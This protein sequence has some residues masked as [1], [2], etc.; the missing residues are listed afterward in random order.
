MQR[1]KILKPGKNIEKAL[2]LKDIEIKNIKIIPSKIRELLIYINVINAKNIEDLKLLHQRIKNYLDEYEA[3]YTLKYN[4]NFLNIDNLFDIAKYIIEQMILEK[5]GLISALVKYELVVFGDEISI[6]LPSDI[7]INECKQ[8][9]LNLEI[10]KRLQYIYPNKN[11]KVYF[12]SNEELKNYTPQD[13]KIDRVIITDTTVNKLIEATGEVFNV[14]IKEIKTKTGLDKKIYTFYITDFKKSLACKKF[15]DANSNVEIGIGDIVKVNGIYKPNDIFNQEYYVDIKSIEK[16]GVANHNIVDDAPKKRVELN[17]KTS[18]SEMYSNINP[19]SIAKTLEKIG[20]SSF[21]VCDI[22]VVHAYPFI[23]NNSSENMKVIFGVDAFLVDDDKKLV[24]N[25][26][27]NINILDETY[28][29]FDIETTGL[30]PYDDKIIEIGAVKICNNEVIDTYSKFINPEIPISEF[31]TNLTSITND[32]VKDADKIDV[33]LPDFFEFIKNSTLV[34]HNAKFDIGFLVQQAKKLGI[35]KTFRY[36]DTMDMARLVIPDQTKF[37]LDALCK[38]LNLINEHHHRAIDD[39]RVTGK[40]FNRLMNLILKLGAIKLEDINRLKINE[41]VSGVNKITILVKDKEGLKILYELISNSFLKYYGNSKPRILKSDL[42][43]YRSHFLIS[44]SPSYGFNEAG[45]LVELYFRGINEKYIE[46]RAEFYDYIQLLPIDCYEKEIAEGEVSSKESIIAM[47]KYLFNLGKKLNKLVVAVGNTMYMHDYE[48]KGKSVL[49]MVSGDFRGYKYNTNA[50]FRTTNVMLE[51]FKYLGD[52][53]AYDI[54]V[55][56]T[57]KIS[58]MIDRIQPIPN[59]FYP[60]KLEN[61]KETVKKLTMDKAYELYGENIPDFIQKR[62]DKELNSI[63]NNGFSVLYLIA[64]K[65]V[66]KSVDNGYLVGSRGSVGSSIVAYLMGITEVN[67]LP[68]HYRCPNKECKNVELFENL[69]TSGVDLPEKICPKCN[70]KYIRDGHA[71]PFEVFMGFHGEKVPDIDL[72]FSSEYQSEIHK[73][74]E[75]IFGKEFVF[76]A[77]TISTTA[78]NNAIGYSKKYF[79]EI[80]KNYI[81]KECVK[82]FGEYIQK[83]PKQEIF[84][85][86]LLKSLESKNFAEICRIAKMIEGTRK[87]TGQHPGGMVVVP[88]DMS[89]YDFTP[90]QKPANDVDSESTT[91]HFDYHVMDE[92]LVKLDIL[93]HDD[94]TTLKILEDLTGVSPFTL[95]LNDSKVL[96]L[97][98]STKALGVTSEQ[99]GTDLGTNGI[100]EFGTNFVKEMLKFTKPTTFT[101]LV[102]ISGLSHGTDVWLNNAKDYIVSNVAKLNEVITVRDDIMNYL[103]SQGMDKGL[104]FKIMEFVRKGKP[105]KQ[106]EQW[107]QYEEE[108]KKAGIKEWYIESCGKIKYMFPKGHAVAY[109]MMAIRIAYFK[110]YYPLEFYTAYLNRKISSFTLSKMFMPVEKLKARLNELDMKANKNPNDKA[111]INVLE[112]LIEMSYRGIELA[113]VNIL[114]SSANYFKIDNGKILIP[115][116]GVDQLGEVVAKNIV[117]ARSERPFSSQEDL[118]KRA[119][120]N[121]SV[122]ET[123]RKYNV[124][125]N[126]SLTDQQTLF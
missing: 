33:V 89:V 46:K 81:I 40:I 44:S 125:N 37:S 27:I 59:G 17:L 105:S 45:E 88:N 3:S 126:L 100:P 38:K 97:F 6:K 98:T 67:G 82:H 87:T 34:A 109:V 24:V 77:G 94:P 19:K 28:V 74:T 71:I 110:V 83:D 91:T 63:I 41:K 65:L 8:N 85:K 75:Q 84:R 69:E 101:E 78:E 9:M 18:M 52:E 13:Q 51:E 117:A 124:I 32:D 25:N 72:N 121:N 12:R 57:N 23:F 66:K 15:Y 48:H 26:D 93:G 95:P 102:R 118:V 76:R 115:F 92:Q 53:I 114:K 35:D 1:I 30:S 20:Y 103:I 107:K 31:T 11:I 14:V 62:I 49:Q 80:N 122:M 56:N 68:P 123:L 64:Q 112:I 54:V 111:E 42:E 90:I 70:T 7:Q 43:K 106:K 50:H 36:M 116:V 73:Y 4:I 60:P 119:G 39:A 47:N 55:E 29:V 96:S 2:G 61:D 104:S 108:M 21:A 120:V 22:G 5:K 10:E 86:D 113:P 79:E 16:L 99:I 58:D